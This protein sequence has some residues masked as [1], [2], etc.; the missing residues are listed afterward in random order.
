MCMP[1]IY[2]INNK[3]RLV[4][5]TN[6]HAPAHVHVIVRAEDVEFKV[7]LADLSVEHVSD[8]QL[9]AS[10]EKMV[11]NFIKDRKQKIQEKW[12]EIQKDQ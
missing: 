2:T 9:S 10:L 11:V 4:I 8:K 12:N 7:Y 6:D 3:I 5:Q 1:T